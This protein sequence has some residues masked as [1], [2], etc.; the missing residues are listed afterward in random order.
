MS[1]YQAD[2]G[3]GWYGAI[4]DESRRNKPM[5]KPDEATVKA[6]VK[7][8][9]WNDYAIRAVGPRIILSINGTQVVDYTE[10]DPAIPQFGRLGLQ[11][12]G[13][14]KTE[15]HFKDIYIDVLPN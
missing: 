9:A 5:A 1:G 3:E 8:G 11:V 14:G 10:A 15:V 2:L 7:P 13:G 6:A 12:H 4:Y